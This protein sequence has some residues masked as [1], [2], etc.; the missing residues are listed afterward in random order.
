M[1]ACL[2]A[3][4]RAVPCRVHCCLQPRCDEPW[5]EVVFE[6]PQQG[7][8]VV[9]VSPL[10]KLTRQKGA[11][12]EEVGSPQGVLNSLGSYIT[13]TYIEE[14]DVVSATSQKQVRRC[15]DAKA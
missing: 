11:R 12:I 13:G 4:C 9:I 14:D 8:I 5:T 7:K 15:F 1:R 2:V 3:S 10:V 6:S